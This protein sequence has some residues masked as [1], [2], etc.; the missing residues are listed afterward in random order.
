[1]NYQGI[2]IIDIIEMIANSILR[3][4]RTVCLFLVELMIAIIADTTAR[5][6]VTKNIP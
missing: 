2:I 4:T 3:K 1:M 5:G 6:I